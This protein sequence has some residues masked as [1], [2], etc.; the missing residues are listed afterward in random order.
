MV[1]RKIKLIWKL[2]RLLKIKSTAPSLPIAI[3]KEREKKGEAT[4]KPKYFYEYNNKTIQTCQLFM[5]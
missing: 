5:G 3:G 1:S 4:I 2:Y